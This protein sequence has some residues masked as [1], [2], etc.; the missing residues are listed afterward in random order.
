V[1]RPKYVEQLRNTG[2]MNSTTWLHLVGSFYEIYTTQCPTHYQTRHFF[3]NSNTNEDTATKFEQQ[4]I[5]C[6]RNEEECVCSACLFRCNIFIG[7]RIIKE[8]PGSVV[9]GTPCIFP[10]VCSHRDVMLLMTVAHINQM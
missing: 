9:S 10:P 7:V 5:R 6:V 1:C 8:M 2:I 4:Y 3:N